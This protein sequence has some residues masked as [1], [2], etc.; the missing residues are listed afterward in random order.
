MRVFIAGAA[1]N[2]TCPLQVHGPDIDGDGTVNLA[3]VALFAGD[4]FGAYAFR[5]DFDWDGVLNLA[6][7]GVMAQAVAATCP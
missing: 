5:S 1:Q 6:D 2:E 7:L 3:D 4:Y